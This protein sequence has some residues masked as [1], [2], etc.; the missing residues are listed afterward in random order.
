MKPVKSEETPE[1]SGG[2][3]S[4]TK[5]PPIDSSLPILPVPLY[6]RAPVAPIVEE[7]YLNIESTRS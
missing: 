3:E 4:P 1:I 6:P 7:T 2:S 5:N